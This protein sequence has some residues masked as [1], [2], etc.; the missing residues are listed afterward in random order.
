M[1]KIRNGS[2]INISRAT[3]SKTHDYNKF[4]NH[5]NKDQTSEVDLIQ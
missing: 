2:L 3:I 1:Q 4:H 5:P